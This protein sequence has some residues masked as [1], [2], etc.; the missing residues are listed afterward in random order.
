[1]TDKIYKRAKAEIH[2]NAERI[3]SGLV[4]Y[5][6]FGLERFEEYVPGVQRKNYT[7]VT[8]NSG[9]AKSKLTKCLYV[10]RPVDF[11]MAHPD[12]GIKLKV[13]YNCLEE[14]K[15]S[16]IQSIYCNKLYEMHGI[17]I[18]IKDLKSITQR[19]ALPLEIRQKVDS[20]DEYFERFEEYVEVIDDIKHPYGIYMKVKEHME[21][22]GKWTRKTI[23]VW[24][25]E[26]NMLVDVEVNDY[27][28]PS[29][30]DSYTVVIT[31][32]VSKL[33][34]KG[35][36][37]WETIGEFS[38]IYC[39][40]LR[41]KYMCSVVNVQQQASDQEKKQFTYAGQSITSKLEPSLDGLA[42]NKTTQ[43]DA[44]EVIGIFSPARHEI[45]DHRGYKITKLDDNYRSL[46]QLKARDGHPNTR[47]GLY[48]DGAVNHFEELP[49][50]KEMTDERYEYYLRKC[51]RSIG[52]PQ[53]TF[54]FGTP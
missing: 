44:D 18:P 54:N 43:R 40:D 32:H 23:P 37:L 42:D 6:P 7:I 4:N 27:Y 15:E 28:V 20:L 29:N 22:N 5:I 33:H 30:P 38:S 21:E 1:M 12:L 19:R 41:D 8:A 3:E 46:I 52:A 36:D 9:V 31:D 47:I 51:G 45:P 53:Q 13:F 26:K 25:K 34:S 50:A 11:V 39:C 48:F 24:N 2:R 16:F 35:K 14:S 17:R 10:I 49:S